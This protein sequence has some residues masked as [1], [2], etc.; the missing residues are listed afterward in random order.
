MNIVFCQRVFCIYWDGNMILSFILLIWF[1]PLLIE[2]VE[3][4]LYPRD[5]SWCIIIIF[6]RF[7]WIQFAS[8]LLKIFPSV[9]IRDIG[10]WFSFLVVYLSG[11]DIRVM[12]ANKWVRIDP[13]SS[14]FWKS[15]RTVVNFS[16][17][18][19]KEAIWSRALLCWNM[20]DYWFSILAI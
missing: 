11:F 10:L 3:P 18:F 9:F 5:K 20:F 16:Y 1:I 7:Y 8:T 6:L 17:V 4:S 13:S 14:T 12:L 15:S 19:D 2:Y